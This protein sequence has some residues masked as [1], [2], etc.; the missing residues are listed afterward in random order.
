MLDLDSSLITSSAIQA[1][2]TAKVRKLFFQSPP[3]GTK[4]PARPAATK[5]TEKAGSKKWGQKNSRFERMAGK[6]K[7][8]QGNKRQW[9]EKKHPVLFLCQSF[10]CQIFVLRLAP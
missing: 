1:Q 6:G 4:S 7:V 3:K 10:P 2:G 8:W 5:A 9:N